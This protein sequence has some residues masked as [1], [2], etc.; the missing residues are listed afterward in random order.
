MI[1]YAKQKKQAKPIH[2]SPC[3]PAYTGRSGLRQ[4]A[5]AGDGN[6]S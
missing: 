4:P 6:A 1:C 3:R 5:A 2:P